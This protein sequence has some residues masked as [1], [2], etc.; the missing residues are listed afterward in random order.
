MALKRSLLHAPS[1]PDIPRYSPEK[2]VDEED[3]GDVSSADASTY[4]TIGLGFFPFKWR[5]R[6]LYA[7]HQT[8]G[9]PVG[10][11]QQV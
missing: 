10:T 6:P 8:V 9:Q 4:T 3:E 5:G 1:P 7:L 11:G 2:H